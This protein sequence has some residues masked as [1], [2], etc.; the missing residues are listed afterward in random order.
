MA[1]FVLCNYFY[2]CPKI[3][4]NF[5]VT[6]TF[7]DVSYVSGVQST[8]LFL[9]SQI[10]LSSGLTPYFFNDPKFIKNLAL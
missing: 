3:S 8:S 2:S 5:I 7:D 9:I 4:R 1:S 10:P 6:T